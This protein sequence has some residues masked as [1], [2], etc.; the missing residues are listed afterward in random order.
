MSKHLQTDLKY[1]EQEI[2]TQSSM[3]EE[4]IE[5]ACRGLRDFRA[6]IAI[7]VIAQEASVN[8]RE[9]RIE[10]ECLKIPGAS[11]TRGGRLATN[12]DGAEN[13]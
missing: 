9:I 3:V 4:M 12:R 13:Q 10:E 1:L 6:D 11:P 8:R 7:H 5:K 2:L